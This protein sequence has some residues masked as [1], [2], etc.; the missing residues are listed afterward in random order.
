MLL[1][2]FKAMIITSAVGSVLTIFLLLIKPLTKRL[3]GFTWQYYSWVIVLIVLMLPVTIATSPTTV[4][5]EPNILPK[6][7]NIDIPQEELFEG[8]NINLAPLA[9]DKF[10]QVNKNPVNVLDSISFE[11]TDTLCYIWLSGLFLMLSINIIK[12]KMF[13]HAIHKNSVVMTCHEAALEKITTLKTSVIDV[14]MLVGIFKPLLLLPDIAMTPENLDYIILHELTHYKRRDLWYKW[15]AMFITTV[16]WFNPFAHIVSK[17]IDE[18]CEISC[19]IAVVA[20]MSENEQ[21]GYMNTILTL[22]MTS[23]TTTKELTTAMASNK[24]QIKK[25]FTMIKSAT[26]K[27]KVTLLVSA[28]VACMILGIFIVASGILNDK[29]LLPDKELGGIID[30]KTNI[31]IIGVEKRSSD[32]MRADTFMLLSLDKENKILNLLSIPRD[33]L[34][35]TDNQE[36]KLSMTSNNDD[37]LDA[38]TNNLGIP[39]SYYVNVNFEAFRSIIDILGGVEFDVPMDMVYEDSYQDLSINIAKGT[40]VLDGKNAE[41]LVRF[42]SG[43]PDGDMSRMAIQQSFVKALIEQK[44]N[45]KHILDISKVYNELSKNIVT[46]YPFD[47]IVKDIAALSEINIDK[48]ESFTLEGETSNRD[49]R[50]FYVVNEEKTK[51]LINEKFAL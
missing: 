39:V 2:I 14:P 40:Q 32:K 1:Q 21:K 8:E 50:L 10:N 6:V 12:Y 25:R 26:K 11:L 48:V 24:N 5:N 37:I 23:I 45:T 20:N 44:F 15:A 38:V 16:H 7:Q 19:D 34:I 42:R 51:T 46:N 43:Y 3:F 9:I 18:E 17:Q 33:T 35:T 47:K 27:S 22:A 4:Y 30:S 49:N 28:V 13:L 29:T 41:H 31:L 36:T